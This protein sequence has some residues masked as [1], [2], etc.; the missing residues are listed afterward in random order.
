MNIW[1]SAIVLFIG[2]SAGILAGM[3]GLG[4]GVVIVPAMMLLVGFSIK[5]ASGTSLAALLL[6]VGLLGAIEYYRQGQINVIA[7]IC[8]VIGLFIGT[9]FGAKFTL[10]LPELYIKRGFGILLLIIAL[11]YLSFSK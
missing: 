4:G 1:Q 11:R 3:F 7:A 6:P 2:M 10:S 5:M 9:Y 8:L